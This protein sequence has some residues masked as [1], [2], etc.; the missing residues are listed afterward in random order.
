MKLL[1]TFFPIIIFLPLWSFVQVERVHSEQDDSFYRDFLVQ[2]MMIARIRE[3]QGDTTAGTLLQ[4]LAKEAKCI[5]MKIPEW[6]QTLSLKAPL[7]YNFH[8]GKKVN[9]R[10][11]DL[12]IHKAAMLYDLPPALIKAVI[13]AESAFVKDAISKKGA[14]CLMQIMPDTANEI[15]L[16]DPFDPQ[17][18]ILGG[19]RLLRKYLDEFGSLKKTLIAYNAG[20]SWV[21][22]S[23]GM[24]GETRRYIRRVIHYYN[25]Y[26]KK[27]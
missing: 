8:V 20:P 14:Q 3:F 24:P 12:L 23:R 17:A 6:S 18:N 10:R 16:I 25:F 21:R 13:H 22:K 5:G 15:H 4:G 7:K 9:S 26:K 19:S 2:R 27:I 1:R 11:Y